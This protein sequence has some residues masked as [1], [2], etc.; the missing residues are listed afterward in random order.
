M[1]SSYCT[2]RYDNATIHGIIAIFLF[3][4]NMQGLLISNLTFLFYSNRKGC[5]NQFS[6]EEYSTLYKT[7]G[8]MIIISFY[9]ER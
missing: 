5:V 6:W 3:L 4:F 1:D 2:N 8:L 7:N 9:V